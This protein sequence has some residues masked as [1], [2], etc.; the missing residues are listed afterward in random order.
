MQKFVKIGWLGASLRMGGIQHFCVYLS[1]FPV[2]SNSPTA[3]TERRNYAYYIPK[4][5]VW[6]KDVPF[7]GRNN[8]KLY[9]GELCPQ[10]P[11]ILGI[12][13]LNVQSNNFRTAQPILF[14]YSS[15][16]AAPRKE[17]GLSS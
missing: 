8:K 10:N 13:S 16:D 5:V 14:I 15:N 4:D 1:F 2:F 11:L 7:G 9:L 12:S 17:F 6:A 3:Q